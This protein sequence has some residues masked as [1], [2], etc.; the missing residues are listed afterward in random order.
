MALMGPDCRT[1]VAGV[2]KVRQVGSV[3][4]RLRMLF[5]AWIRLDRFLVHELKY[6]HIP[7]ARA[8]SQMTPMPGLIY[9]GAQPF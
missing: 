6:T 2:M 5:S 9:I 1:H 8:L 3:T 4:V 7:D